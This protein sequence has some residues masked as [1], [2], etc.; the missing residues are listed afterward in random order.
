MMTQVGARDLDRACAENGGD[1][2]VGNKSVLRGDDL[3]VAVQE[4]VSEK[5]EHFI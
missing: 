5:F 3:V 2:L 1:E 4:G